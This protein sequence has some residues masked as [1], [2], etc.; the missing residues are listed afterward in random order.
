MTTDPTN[1]D[2]P[3]GEWIE[4]EVNDRRHPINWFACWGVRL[5][6][7]SEASYR[8]Q[9]ASQENARDK[10]YGKAMHTESD[11]GKLIDALL[12]IEA[13]GGP[14]NKNCNISAIQESIGVKD[15]YSKRKTHVVKN[16]GETGTLGLRGESCALPKRSSCSTMFNEAFR[17]GFARENLLSTLT[18]SFSIMLRDAFR[19]GLLASMFRPAGLLDSLQLAFEAP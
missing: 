4:E 13:A 9:L 1:V 16:V 12:A 10:P 5:D 8:Q 17:M 7:S 3:I 19:A 2:S 14:G 11:Y 6:P 18:L 15:L